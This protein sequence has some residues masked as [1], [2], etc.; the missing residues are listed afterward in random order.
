MAKGRKERIIPPSKTD[1]SI[2]SKRLLKRDKPSGRVMAD[3]AV[4]KKQGVR[5]NKP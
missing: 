4:A 5:R 2:A 1:L 3:A